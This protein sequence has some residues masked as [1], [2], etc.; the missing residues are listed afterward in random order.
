MHLSTSLYHLSQVSSAASKTD[1]TETSQCSSQCPIF[2]NEAHDLEALSTNRAEL[3]LT[4]HHGSCQTDYDVTSIEKSSFP[5]EHCK[6]LS[7]YKGEDCESANL[8]TMTQESDSHVYQDRPNDLNILSPESTSTSPRSESAQSK[9]LE[10]MEPLSGTKMFD[11]DSPDSIVKSSG[12]YEISRFESTDITEHKT[13]PYQA[14]GV[15]IGQE[16]FH[17]SV[18]EELKITMPDSDKTQET[19]LSFILDSDKESPSIPTAPLTYP[20][21]AQAIY[22]VREPSLDTIIPSD[23]FQSDLNNENSF[24]P[25]SPASFLE[26]KTKKE[27]ETSEEHFVD[28]PD[29]ST[30]DLQ[31]DDKEFKE[32]LFASAS[33]ENEGVST[34]YSENQ[35][36][37]TESSLKTSQNE[38]VSSLSDVTPETATDARHFIFEEF[39]P[40]PSSELNESY[41]NND[42]PKSEED[43]EDHLNVNSASSITPK[44]EIT[45]STSEGENSITSQCAETGSPTTISSY[46]PP[47]YLKGVLSG[48]E[49]PANEC[50]D[51]EPYFDCK[52]AESDFSETEPDGSDPKMNCSGSVPLIQVHNRTGHQK[53]NRK[54]VLSSGSEDFEDAYIVH[55]P[56]CNVDEDEKELLHHTESSEDEFTL[57]EAPQPPAL[58]SESDDTDKYL[59]RVR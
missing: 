27:L 59:T 50:S 23:I 13:T 1:L 46:I 40:K 56:L 38:D 58:C 19:D 44:K 6:Q 34:S 45:S 3:F 4:Q 11:Q 30:A 28:L 7:F 53:I 48:V 16:H 20:E 39:M 41:F 31:L 14:Y 26:H 36:D 21:L 10:G 22:E 33:V 24:E 2:S 57:C 9:Q 12:D 25:S 35:Q 18:Q 29:G 17:A 43:S 49:S 51:Q 55:E 52:Q 54:M 37:F 32:E 47:K 5:E 42:R 15:P 8:T